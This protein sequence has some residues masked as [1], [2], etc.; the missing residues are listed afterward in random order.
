MDRSN[1]S[2]CHD[3][4]DPLIIRPTSRL[5]SQMLTSPIARGWCGLILANVP[6]WSLHDDVH[7]PWLAIPPMSAILSHSG[8]DVSKSFCSKW[9]LSSNTSR[10][11]PAY[12]ARI[13]G[14]N[15][16]SEPDSRLTEITVGR[17]RPIGAPKNGSK[18][19]ETVPRE[20]SK[21]CWSGMEIMD[22]T[23]QLIR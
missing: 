5:L 4:S 20:S 6:A 11:Y 15:W 21:C 17:S 19:A 12:H 2:A 1:S 22:G 10:R 18:E 3:Y 16:L 13:R 14:G 8:C 9:P 23:N 7:R